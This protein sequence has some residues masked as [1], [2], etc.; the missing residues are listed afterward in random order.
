MTA[1]KLRL[2]GFKEAWS[3]KRLGATGRI[4]QERTSDFSRYPLYSLTIEK[5]VTKKTE[6]YERG[7]LVSKT[8]DIFKIVH[9]GNFVTNPMNLRFGAVGYSK[10]KDDV[11]VSGYYDVFELDDNKCSPFWFNFLKR[12]EMKKR[13]EDIATGSLIEKKRVHVNDL[14]NLELPIPELN[15]RKSIGEC[16][17]SLDRL[18]DAEVSRLERLRMLKV[19]C[20]EK[21]FVKSGETAPRLRIGGYKDPWVVGKLSDWL[22]ISD[23]ING[24][25]FSKNEVLSVSG[26]YGI[27]NQIEYQGRSYAGASVARYRVVRKGN[28][29][30]TKSPLKAAPFG[31]IKTAKQEEGIVSPLYAVYAAKDNCDSNF[32]QSYFDNRNRLNSY[33][34]GLVNKGAKNTILITDAAAL[35]GA[36]CL[37]PTLDEQRDIGRFFNAMERVLMVQTDHIRLLRNIR[38]ACVERMF[39]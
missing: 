6:R 27:I 9:P 3:P 8:G 30:Y 12:E 36:V 39:V 33:L 22:T 26:E 11:S 2:A 16:L 20:H 34:Q 19:A 37:P 5:G 17:T 7:F 25:R 21:I 24:D 1:P 35:D 13:Y 32:I 14:L 28:V 4:L 18:I 38:S 29:V 23:E 15:E 31:I 10:E